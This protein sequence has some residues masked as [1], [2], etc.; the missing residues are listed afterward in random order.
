MNQGPD[1]TPDASRS[2]PA[3]G[4]DPYERLGIAVDAPF[5]QVQQAKQARL[6]EVGDDPIA[7]S[8]IEAAYDAVLMDRLKERQQG[9]VSQA[10]RSASQREQVPPSPPRASLPS[11]P[12]LPALPSLAVAGGSGL[13]L[14]LASGRERW[15]PLVTLGLLLVLVLLPGTAPELLLALATLVTALNL[16]RRN[17]RFLPAVGF[18]F[19]LLLLG[20]AL[21]SLLLQLVD[22]T[23][24]LGL[25]LDPRQVQSVPALLLLLAGALWIA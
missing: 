9:R 10:A 6:T 11:L 8:R 18:S 12:S 13:R 5:D 22:P 20:L 21:G 15:F 24:P 4:Q 2:G 3:E 19:G 25:P 23:L 1:P 7:R 16:Q 17:G 14:S